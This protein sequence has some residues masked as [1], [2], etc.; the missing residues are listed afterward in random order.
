[1]DMTDDIFSQNL[2]MDTS[3]ISKY[4]SHWQT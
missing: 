1:M 4:G 2:G 3:N